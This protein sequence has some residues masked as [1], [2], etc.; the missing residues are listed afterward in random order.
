MDEKFKEIKDR[1]GAGCLFGY[2]AA[3]FTTYRAGG[4]FEALVTP[5]AYR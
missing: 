4:P 3:A 5:A 2:S 1:F